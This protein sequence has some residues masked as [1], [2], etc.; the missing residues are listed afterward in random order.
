MASKI[1][2]EI[3]GVRINTKASKRP[4]PMQEKPVTWSKLNLK[5]S[6]KCKLP[7]FLGREVDMS[8]QAVSQ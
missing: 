6:W 7:R 5:G 4:Q 2:T 1:T 3:G 8:N